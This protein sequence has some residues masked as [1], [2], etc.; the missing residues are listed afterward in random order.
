M[1]EL[2]DFFWEVSPGEA[3][4]Y[5]PRIYLTRKIHKFFARRAD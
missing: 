3:F 2:A 1:N 5:C 4:P